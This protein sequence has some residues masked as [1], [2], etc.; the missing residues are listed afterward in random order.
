MS[1]KRTGA[2][3]AGAKTKRES[4][5][6]RPRAPMPPGRE[7]RPP[8]PARAKVTL[9]DADTGAAI[10]RASYIGTAALV[11]TGVAA[12]VAPHPFEVPAL[13]VALALFFAGTG[14]F[15]WAYFVAIGRSRTDE[16]SLAGI[17]GLAG[18]TPGPVR[19]RLFVS[20]AVE[21]AVAVGTASARLYSTLSFG[22][23]AVMWGL[24]MAGLWGARHGAFPPREPVN[25]R[26]RRRPSPDAS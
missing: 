10:V 25:R 12:A 26:S 7:A 22:I 15:I 20:I 4:R 13:V 11:V 21:A 8:R 23:L 17:Y 16:M 24:G 2:G 3:G 1:R 19:V 9:A 18:S 6:K 5:E 14:A